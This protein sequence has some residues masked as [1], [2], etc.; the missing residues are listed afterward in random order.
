VLTDNPKGA[1]YQKVPWYTAVVLDG[2]KYIR[3]L[4]PDVP[5]ELYHLGSDPE[6]LNN[7][8]GETKHAERLGRLREALAAELQRTA[9][10]AAMLPPTRQ[11]QEKP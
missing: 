9:A 3:Y 4:Q 11:L 2:W 5:E 10:P 8:I 6:E 7:L 1:I